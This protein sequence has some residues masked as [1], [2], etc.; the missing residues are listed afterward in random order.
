MHLNWWGHY[1]ALIYKK[2]RAL[3]AK[4]YANKKNT[5]RPYFDKVYDP[6]KGHPDPMG[7]LRKKCETILGRIRAEAIDEECEFYAKRM[8]FDIVGKP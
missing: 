5:W 3:H 6:Y 2:A 8:E 4:A 1:T 7:T